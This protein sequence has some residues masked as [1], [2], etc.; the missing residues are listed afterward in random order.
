MAT[1][2]KTESE[3]SF[4]FLNLPGERRYRIYRLA[5]VKKGNTRIAV[6]STGFERPAITRV[7][8]Q[9]RQE[10]MPI[11]LYENKFT[12]DRQSKASLVPTIVFG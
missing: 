6:S 11:F 2:N 10:C 4:R 9:T 1:Y 12:I 7:S 3:T 8:K 5:L